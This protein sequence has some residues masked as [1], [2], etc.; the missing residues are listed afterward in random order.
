MEIA[1]HDP[2][3]GYY[4]SGPSRLGRGG[5]FFTASD[6]GT[7]FGECLARQL[8]E[9][10]RI[11]GRPAPFV[12][13][14]LGC[15]RGLLAKDVREA[16]AAIPESLAGR[17]EARLVDS[18]PGMRAAAAAAVP[19][20]RVSAPAEVA[21]GGVG[22]IVA[23]ELFDALPVHRVRRREG[24][25][26]EIRVGLDGSGRLAEV[27]AEP[28]DE[29]AAY[30]ARY[31]LA[32]DDGDETEACLAVRA[33]M[34]RAASAI[35]RGFLLVV[36]YG[37]SARELYGPRRPRG[38]LLAYHRHRTGEDWLSRVGDQDLTAHVNFTA[39]EDEARASGFRLIGLTT[40]DRFLIGNGILR[41]FEEAAE[42]RPDA[43]QVKR[44]LQA[45]QLIHPEG[46]GRTFKVMIFGRGVPEGTTLE[47]LADPFA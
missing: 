45:M 13:V 33:A 16:L 40:Q 17:L 34:E 38:T 31:G 7:L 30:A 5:D 37:H 1:L 6:V 44:R 3:H 36:D 4:A 18:S 26:V 14:E 41:S 46:M 23:V 21:R 29:L 35:D 10:D 22:C 25:L 24:R 2:D 47:G 8:V 43:R 27:E 39:L 32:P 11:L 19:D 42:A 9:M 20:A 28:G 12:Y 15:G